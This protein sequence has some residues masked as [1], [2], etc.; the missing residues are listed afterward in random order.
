MRLSSEPHHPWFLVFLC[1]ECLLHVWIWFCALASCWSKNTHFSS[2]YTFPELV[3]S[4]CFKKVCLCSTLSLLFGDFRATC[5]FDISNLWKSDPFN[6]PVTGH[7]HM[8]WKERLIPTESDW[9]SFSCVVWC[10]S[11]MYFQTPKTPLALL[12]ESLCQELVGVWIRTTM[13]RRTLQYKASISIWVQQKAVKSCFK[14]RKPVVLY[15][16]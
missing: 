3:Y 8:K 16:I 1:I 14:I 15:L 12:S 2:E 6:V 4:W 10:S 5:T 7:D 13:R 9:P 11:N